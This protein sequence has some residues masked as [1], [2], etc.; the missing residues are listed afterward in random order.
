MNNNQPVLTTKYYTWEWCYA[1]P[2][3]GDESGYTNMPKEEPKNHMCDK[4]HKEFV[5][6]GIK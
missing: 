1:C 2:Y 5:V 3:C 6:V 4:C